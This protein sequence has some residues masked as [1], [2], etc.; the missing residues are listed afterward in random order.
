MDLDATLAKHGN[1]LGEIES[2]VEHIKGLMS[3]ADGNVE[4]AT[5]QIDQLLAFKSMV[6]DVL[7][8]MEKAV[9]DVNVIAGDIA[10]IKT[11]LEPA[12]AWI[13]EQ[14]KATGPDEPKEAAELTA[15]RSEAEQPAG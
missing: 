14:Q 7:P 6:E 2:F 4:K 13:A 9:M 5:D 10:A 8:M 15:E 12:L 3:G 1:R 11:Q